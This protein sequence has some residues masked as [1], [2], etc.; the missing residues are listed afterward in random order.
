MALPDVSADVHLSRRVDEPAAICRASRSGLVST[1]CGSG[2]SSDGGSRGS[3]GD[4]GDDARAA[5][6]VA[7]PARAA[8]AGAVE[9]VAAGWDA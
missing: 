3:D 9:G 1:G 6:E 7:E 8:E 5:V 2:N 4:G